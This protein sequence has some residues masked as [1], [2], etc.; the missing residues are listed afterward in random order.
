MAEAIALG[1]GILG[2]AGVIFT[3][4]RYN[5]DDSTAVIHQQAQI[6]TDM[7]VLNDELRVTNAELKRQV[8]ELREQIEQMRTELARGRS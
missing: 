6:V 5:R 8:S 1:I 3:A 7:H 4:L 2:V